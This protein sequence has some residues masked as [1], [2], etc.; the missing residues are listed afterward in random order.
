MNDTHGS[1]EMDEDAVKLVA[2]GADP[3]PTF[4]QLETTPYPPCPECH[5]EVTMRTDGTQNCARCGWWW[6]PPSK[7]PSLVSRPDWAIKAS[8]P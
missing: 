3:G 7:R 4:A 2:M 5:G 8:K 6:L 1:P